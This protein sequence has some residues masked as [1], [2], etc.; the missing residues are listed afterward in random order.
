MG[1]GFGGS[2][3]AP[4]YVQ[5]VSRFSPLGS[6]ELGSNGMSLRDQYGPAFGLRPSLGKCDHPVFQFLFVILRITVK[7]CT[8]TIQGF[9]G[10]FSGMYGRRQ[11]GYGAPEPITSCPAPLQS[12]VQSSSGQTC[13]HIPMNEG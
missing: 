1:S 5:T 10:R 3:R 7:F 12:Y 6:M 13:C 4:Q 11:F 2:Y 9:E 8:Y